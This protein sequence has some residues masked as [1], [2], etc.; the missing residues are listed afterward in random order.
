MNSE[1]YAKVT[2]ADDF[3]LKVDDKIKRL[4][5]EVSWNEDDD[6]KPAYICISKIGNEGSRLYIDLTKEE[7]LFLANALKFYAGLK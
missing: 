1:I 3:V 7:T 5:L 6:E 4:N 2:Y